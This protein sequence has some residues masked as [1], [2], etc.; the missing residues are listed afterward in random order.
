MRTVL[1]IFFKSDG[2]SPWI[3]LLCL[4]SANFAAGIG[5]ATVLPLLTVATDTESSSPVF[6][7][8]R[9][10]FETVGLPLDIKP[11]LIIVITALIAKSVLV[12]VA[13]CYTG[14]A[15]AEITTRLR[16]KVAR[17][18][19]DSK[20]E[21]Y[22]RQPAGRLNHAL[23]ALT[24]SAGSAYSFSASFVAQAIETAILTI[25]AFVVSWKVALAGLIAG[26]LIAAALD[27]YVRR[28]RKAGRKE[29]IRQRELSIAWGNTLSNF[30]VLKGMA[31]HHAFLGMF[32]SK[33]Q[34]WRGI[35]R[36]QV[37]NREGRSG[38]Q[39]ILFALLLGVGAYLAMV[40][41][42]IPVVELI[43][44]FAVINR[45]V[46]GIGKLQAH[47]QKAVAG[48]YPFIELHTVMQEIRDAAEPSSG[49]R[50]AKLDKAVRLE[51]VTFSHGMVP[52]LKD[53]NLDIPVGEITVLT[54]PSGA[55]KTTIADLVLGIYWP[56][57]GQITVDGVPLLEIELQSWR[58][59]IG[60]EAQDAGLF[61]DTVLA[62]VRLG[63]ATITE[64][65]V[66]EALKLAQAWDFIEQRPD[67]IYTTTGETGMRFSG[68]QRKR[69]S[70]A[71]AIVRRPRLLILDE[72]T[73][74]LDPKNEARI[75]QS[76]LEL[77]SDMAVLAITHRPAFV[78]IA[79]KVYEMADY[80]LR[81]IDPEPFLAAAAASSQSL[82]SVPSGPDK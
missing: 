31:R 38:F 47:F 13:N 48:E 11:L 49:T 51:G 32:E 79:D 20:W 59:L 25:V 80:K 66:E 15:I 35:S 1:R 29:I 5:L 53:V 65:E 28:S 58:R 41:W 70:L 69:L 6:K 46:R 55:G 68:G 78:E 50:T 14:Y 34:E 33:L 64:E 74:G 30:K 9:D 82:Y 37:Y 17:L 22:V 26:V 45:A 81:P 4:L 72:V 76:I 18:F 19:M 21:W 8:V 24:S 10:F 62:N 54:G 3:S 57:E 75:C 16:R 73:A 61:H 44:I 42:A 52:V 77:K 36:K 40:V 71:R 7:I 27:R 67:G 23:L 12:L 2:A 60:Y 43:I 63:D 56:N 39:D